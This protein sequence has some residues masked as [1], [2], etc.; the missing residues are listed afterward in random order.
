MD[1]LSF[2]ISN[3]RLPEL[4]LFRSVPVDVSF[5][6]ISRIPQRR[7]VLLHSA[8]HCNAGVNPHQTRIS[9]IGH[10]VWPIRDKLYLNL[11]CHRK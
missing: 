8:Q 2:Q 7:L 3:T 6:H 9:I 5:T 10:C 1:L 11:H 4:K